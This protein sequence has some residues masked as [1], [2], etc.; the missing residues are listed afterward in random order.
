MTHCCQRLEEG[1]GGSEVF[2]VVEHS[3]EPHASTCQHWM[4]LPLAQIVGPSL[5]L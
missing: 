1:F 2:A 4:K 3:I 5:E